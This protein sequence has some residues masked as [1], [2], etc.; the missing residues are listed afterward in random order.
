MY[1]LCTSNGGE[2]QLYLLNEVF[3]VYILSTP[4]LS[5][6]YPRPTL[7]NT[8]LMHCVPYQP[9]HPVFTHSSQVMC[10]EVFVLAAVL[11]YMLYMFTIFIFSCIALLLTSK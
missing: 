6:A 5:L 9:V 10:G 3:K 1:D 2:Y 7:P 11:L 4:S 8:L